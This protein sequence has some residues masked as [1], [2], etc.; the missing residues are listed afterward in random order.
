[1]M[2]G[3]GSTEMKEL[4]GRVG[5][6]ES[7]VGACKRNLTEVWTELFAVR[8][9]IADLQRSVVGLQS[10][11]RGGDVEN[12]QGRKAAAGEMSSVKA[13]AGKGVQSNAPTV[14]RATPAEH[15]AAVGK[16]GK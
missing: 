4:A 6:L 1:M 16:R 12:A 15:R 9:Q 11:L 5:F 10:A 3:G 2:A 8:K 7:E 13:S 14:A